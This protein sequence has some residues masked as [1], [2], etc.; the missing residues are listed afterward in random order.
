MQERSDHY[1]SSSEGVSKIFEQPFTVNPAVGRRACTDI[2]PNWSFR[3]LVAELQGSSAIVQPGC[4]ELPG[5]ESW[6]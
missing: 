4:C 1:L 3:P 6:Q 2:T 5:I